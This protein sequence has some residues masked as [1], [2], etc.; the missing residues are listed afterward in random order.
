VLSLEEYVE[1][2]PVGGKEAEK[3]IRELRAARDILS[4]LADREEEEAR[5]RQLDN[6]AAI[7]DE[8]PSL[9]GPQ[10]IASSQCS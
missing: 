5:L 3:T 6:T 1:E 8:I 10:G 9:F 7:V 2:M 4:R